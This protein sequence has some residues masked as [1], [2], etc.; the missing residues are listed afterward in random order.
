MNMKKPQL[1]VPA[2]SG[3]RPGAATPTNTAPVGLPVQGGN[4]V[5]EEDFTDVVGGFAL[6]AE[7]LHHAKVI[8]FSL[9]ESKAGNPQYVWQILITAGPSKGIE[10]RYWTSLLPQ[11]RWKVVEALEAIGIEASGTVARFRRGDVIGRPCIIEVVH[12]TYQDRDTHKIQ[13]VLPPD[14]DS[15]AHANNN[16]PF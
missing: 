6:A 7:G 12:D 8:D 11:A 4:D 13:R 9:T 15:A 10:V 3:P 5:Y 2:T 14:A 1:P 16:K